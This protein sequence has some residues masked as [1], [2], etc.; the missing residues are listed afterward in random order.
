MNVCTRSIPC[1]LALL[2]LLAPS[3][4]LA[5]ST[6]EAYGTAAETLVPV[7]AYD[8]EGMDS[9][10]TTGWEP[11][12]DRRFRTGGT[13]GLTA[14]LNL[15]SGVEVT[16]TEIS[17]CDMDPVFGLEGYFLE[18]PEPADFC[19]STATVFSPSG[20]PGCGTFRTTLPAPRTAN[21]PN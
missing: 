3:G 15:P 14:G 21:S 7:S 9:S 17:G 10:S 18:C 12:T 16:A 1:A 19:N 4:A 8:F 5:Q 13:I 2:S 11:F 6:P 20:T